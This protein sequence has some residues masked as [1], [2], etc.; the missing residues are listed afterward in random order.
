MQT[1]PIDGGTAPAPDVDRSTRSA[2][3]DAASGAATSSM[4]PAVDTDGAQGHRPTT[5]LQQGIS[6][7]KQYT[8]GTV[9][10]CMMSTA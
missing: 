8:D 6:K 1:D 2:A 10:W 7:P 4:A 5:R 9:R 3:V